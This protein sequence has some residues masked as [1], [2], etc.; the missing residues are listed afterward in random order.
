MAGENEWIWYN[1]HDMRFQNIPS[2]WGLINSSTG[3]VVG[4]NQTFALSIVMH[5]ENGETNMKYYILKASLRAK[6]L[7]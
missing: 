5:K 1:G 7:K 3:V 4:D 2:N 6:K